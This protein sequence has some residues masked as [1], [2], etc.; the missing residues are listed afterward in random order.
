MC[1]FIFS[2]NSN[3]IFDEKSLQHRGPDNFSS[4]E[5][6]FNEQ[7][8]NFYHYRLNIVDN[9]SLSN[10]PFVSNDKVLIFNGEIYNH[11]ELRKM[12]TTRFSHNFATFSDTEVLFYGLV[13]YGIE[14]IQYCIGM[15]SFVFHD[16]KKSSTIIARDHFGIKPLY[17]DINYTLFASEIKPFKEIMPL[18][19]NLYTKSLYFNGIMNN[20][21]ETF[22]NEINQL[23]PGNY[24]LLQDGIFKEELT[25]P[26]FLLNNNNSLK[27]L[28]HESL[29]LHT[30]SNHDFCCTLSGGIDS[31][32]IVSY[33]KDIGLNFTSFIFDSDSN[34][35][36]LKWAQYVAD[37]KDI[38]LNCIKFPHGQFD[39]YLDKTVYDQEEPFISPSIVMQN[40]LYSQIALEHKVVLGGQGADELF[41][42]YTH[43]PIHTIRTLIDCGNYYS[44]ILFLF[45]NMY[46]YKNNTLLMLLN[47]ILKNDI[48][49]LKSALDYD[50]RINRLP[51]LL[52]YDDKNSMSYSIESRVPFCNQKIIS[53]I[54]KNDDEF[55]ISQT[56]TTKKVLRDSFKSNLPS[57]IYKRY[58]KVGFE[59]PSNMN[60]KYLF[61]KKCYDLW[62]KH[63]ISF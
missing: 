24:L 41:C 18:S 2:I 22:F 44:L 35:S 19:E 31:S 43:Y 59:A 4:Y 55:L 16:I 3:F 54:N 49:S 36:E 12:I 58:D 33:L 6:Q 32:A 38:H 7:K 28:L 11:N 25:L 20:P 63:Y 46:R 14:F 39:F 30:Q 8:Y 37:E 21:P 5:V 26:N 61:R 47:C 51:T 62:R 40:Y 17:Y 42:G 29:N 1:G 13:Y 23:K 27:D 48:K 15:F 57:L 9:N 34:N 60:S 50:C 52:R 56:S 10:Q 45:N 53:F